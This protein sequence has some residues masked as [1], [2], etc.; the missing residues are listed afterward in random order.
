MIGVDRD[1]GNLKS[2]FLATY[3]G[4]LSPICNTIAFVPQSIA[5]ITGQT[6]VA[7]LHVRDTTL[8]KQAGCCCVIACTN[9]QLLHTKN[10]L[11][12]CHESGK[13]QL[14]FPFQH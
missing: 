14:R 9:M 1:L 11:L 6:C 8:W 4:T 3:T 10:S 12:C 7:M 2:G 5:H 13:V